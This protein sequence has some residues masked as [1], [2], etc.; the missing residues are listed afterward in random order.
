MQQSAVSV[1]GY[2]ASPAVTSKLIGT[3]SIVTQSPHFKL[4]WATYHISNVQT[5]IISWGGQLV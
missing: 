4:E 5:C 1:V 2:V 3:I